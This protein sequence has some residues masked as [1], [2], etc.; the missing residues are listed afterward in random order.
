M[1]A[2]NTIPSA[3]APTITAEI[4]LSRIHSQHRGQEEQGLTTEAITYPPIAMENLH[5]HFHRNR[6][7]CSQQYA[8]RYRH[9]RSPDNRMRP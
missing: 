1:Q 6:N 2:G 7:Q 9:S 4:E 5:H 8:E 3:L